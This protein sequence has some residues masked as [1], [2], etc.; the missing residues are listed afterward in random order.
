MAEASRKP[1]GYNPL[2]WDCDD[3]GCFNVKKRP[4]IE[5]FADCFPG[6]ISF[7]DVD[8]RVEINGQ[9]LELEWK[10]QRGPIPAGQKIAFDRLTSRGD[11][12]VFVV[13]GDAETMRV[14]A[15]Q[16]LMPKVDPRWRDCD[17]TQLHTYVARWA[18]WAQKGSGADRATNSTGPESARGNGDL[19]TAQ[20]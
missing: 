8:A 1:L 20:R 9:F 7:G 6:R 2:R 3:K 4:K 13:A 15:I 19:S 18:S 12:T 14:D 16:I 17:F 11:Y 5:A 10:G